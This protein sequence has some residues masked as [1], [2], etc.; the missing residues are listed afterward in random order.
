V[1]TFARPAGAVFHS[2]PTAINPSRVTNNL[3]REYRQ[4]TMESCAVA[5]A[6]T[7]QRRIG[8]RKNSVTGKRPLTILFWNIFQVSHLFAIF[9]RY[10][11]MPELGKHRRINS[12]AASARKNSGCAYRSEDLAACGAER[13]SPSIGGC[14]LAHLSG[15]AQDRLF[16]ATERGKNGDAPASD[17]FLTGEAG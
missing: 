13:W 3:D 12:L 8:G 16:A 11:P 5:R 15:S 17:Q 4:F 7:C 14:P 1:S 10:R 2:P 9:C 6:T